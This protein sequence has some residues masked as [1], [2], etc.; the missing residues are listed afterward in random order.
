MGTEN[1]SEFWP[2]VVGGETQKTTSQLNIFIKCINGDREIYS[3]DF[4]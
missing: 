1:L 2:K 3:N 4:M